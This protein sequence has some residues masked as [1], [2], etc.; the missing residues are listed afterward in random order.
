MT[1][2][3]RN[4]LI[5]SFTFFL[6]ASLAADASLDIKKIVK[7]LF[8]TEIVAFEDNCLFDTPRDGS[9]VYRIEGNRNNIHRRTGMNAGIVISGGPVSY[10]HPAQY[11][12]PT[13]RLKILVTSGEPGIAV[14]HNGMKD[15]SG[16]ENPS[17]GLEVLLREKDT[18]LRDL[19][20]GKVICV[21]PEAF[22]RGHKASL[23][24]FWDFDM[25]TMRID[26]PWASYSLRM[27]DTVTRKGGFA[28]RASEEPGADYRV[29]Q[30]QVIWQD[31]RDVV[32]YDGYDTIY[33]LHGKQLKKI[34]SVALPDGLT[35]YAASSVDLRREKSLII[36]G[37]PDL[38]CEK[39][40]TIKGWAVRD[41]KTG[42]LDILCRTSTI[43]GCF[44]FQ[45]GGSM[46]GYW[47]V[48][49]WNVPASTSWI[50]WNAY[51]KGDLKGF[52]TPFMTGQK[53]EGSF[54]GFHDPGN[55]LDGSMCRYL[56]I[57]Q[58]WIGVNHF[59]IHPNLKP[60]AP[61]DDIAMPKPTNPA[62]SHTGPAGMPTQLAVRDKDR[63]W[64]EQ[65]AYK[66]NGLHSQNRGYNIFARR[67]DWEGPMCPTEKGAA[68]YFDYANMTPS[69]LFPGM[70]IAPKYKFSTSESGATQCDYQSSDWLTWETGRYVVTE[71]LP[72]GMVT[73]P[74]Q[75]LFDCK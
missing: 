41:L 40:D 34:P 50:D 72:K 22:P 10:I 70:L 37:G 5:I 7:P 3:F 39:T 16:N 43:N 36:M 28:L 60:Y 63:A 23:S 1:S 19:K 51:D 6:C 46:D 27:P 13:L 65:W 57:D 73:P 68:P 71:A 17:P 8:K 9:L 14:C 33:D 55:A 66:G 62:V 35:A 20:T 45:G 74:F 24:I 53:N 75:I 15:N 4:G 52:I 38:S 58:S 49:S 21:I 29:S 42:A 2:Y 32:L 56:R 12:R 54:L 59:T 26:M 61:F 30:V 11:D 44:P 48:Q 69:I 67:D 25:K 18:A 31:N 64:Y 47:I